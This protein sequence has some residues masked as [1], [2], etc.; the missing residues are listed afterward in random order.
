MSIINKML[1]DLE[2]RHNHYREHNQLM[3]GDLAPV[4]ETGFDTPKKL[5]Y[6]FMLVCFFLTALSV[7]VYGYFG[8]GFSGAGNTGENYVADNTAITSLPDR[9]NNQV[10]QS[11][12][13]MPLLQTTEA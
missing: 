5:P 3:L 7:A 8:D 12:S 10:Q 1:S 13:I 9:S 11:A 6:N 4:N 2:G